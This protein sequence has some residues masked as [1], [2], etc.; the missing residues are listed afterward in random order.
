MNENTACRFSWGGEKCSLGRLQ[1]QSGVLTDRGQPI[2]DYVN[3]E[4]EGKAEDMLCC[5]FWQIAGGLRII[6]DILEKHWAPIQP[7]H[8]KK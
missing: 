3:P 8:S 1:I 4:C 7:L 6:A 2:P 5:P